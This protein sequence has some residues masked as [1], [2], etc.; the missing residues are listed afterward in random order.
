M[1]TTDDTEP[2]IGVTLAGDVLS[3][4]LR[5]GAVFARIYSRD[6]G[7]RW[8]FDGE[9]TPGAPPI[10]GGLF[11][12]GP[13]SVVTPD[14]KQ[15]QVFGRGLDTRV[16][17]A[18]SPDRGQTW[19]IP[20]AW[21]PIGSGVFRSGPAAA[22]SADGNELHVFGRGTDDR[23][24][25]AYSTTGGKTWA[26]AWGPVGEHAFASAPATVLSANGNQLHVFARG[27]DNKI[28][29]T[30]SWNRGSTFSID[31]SPVDGADLSPEFT[32]APAATLSADGKHLHIFGRGKD[33]KVWR[34]HSQDGGKTW[35]GAWT[36]IDGGTIATS[37][38]VAMSAD[39]KKLYVFGLDRAP[40][41]MG[42]SPDIVRAFSVDSGAH[43]SWAPVAVRS[44][45][46][47]Q[48]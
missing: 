33:G 43:W 28:W 16:Y 2:S 45:T 5:E 10:G 22:L 19:S 36:A 8:F 18:Y 6:E 9:D 1:T 38:S 12:S 20:G 4:I 23:I 48:R 34:I 11:T 47:A 31:W 40:P 27:S 17:R 24:W 37:P 30:Y 26:Y 15:L 7:Q 3:I 25:R 41:G 29:R 39:G 46:R 21:E 35:L 14:G 42:A 13:S 44:A 32:H